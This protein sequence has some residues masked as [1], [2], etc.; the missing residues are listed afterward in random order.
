MIT[1]ISG[2]LQAVD[3]SRAV[4]G[5]GG[6][7]Y[8]VLI[9]DFTRR[10]LQA[11]IGQ[12]VALF[13]LHFLEGNPAHGRLVPRLIGFLAEAEREFFEMFCQVDGVGARKALRAM[14]RPVQDVAV[15]IAEKDA[16]G[17][18]T[19]PG[20]GAATADRIVAKLH[21][22]M[23]KFALLVRK[24]VPA[25]ETAPD[26]VQETYAALR[27]LG[28]SEQEARSL[29]DRALADGKRH[30]NVEALLQAVYRVAMPLAQAGNEP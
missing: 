18:T 11:S 3:E 20:I 24:D 19:L 12:T 27:A 1:K 25:S 26:V 30:A 7:D 5:L 17:L 16:K 8:E 14:V 23:C 28:H 22:K 29:L 2:T 4:L 21:R 6:L 10:Q 15:M 9:P 13:T